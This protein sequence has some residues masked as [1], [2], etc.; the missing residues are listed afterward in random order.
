M[1]ALSV[2][3]F[4]EGF[5]LGLAREFATAFSI[6]LAILIHKGIAGMSL[7]ISLVRTFPD[8]LALCKWLVFSFAISSPIGIALGMA[9]ANTDDIIEVIFS[10]LAAGTFVYIGCSEVV[11]NEFSVPGLRV[12]KLLAYLVGALIIILLWFAE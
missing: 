5:A 8:D 6:F 12:V 3:S 4:F 1:I 11:V 2:H 9:L 7:G 10:S